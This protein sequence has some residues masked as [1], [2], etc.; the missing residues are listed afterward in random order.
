MNWSRFLTIPFP[1]Q[2]IFLSSIQ[3]F[4]KEKE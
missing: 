2:L 4:E 3:I 1:F